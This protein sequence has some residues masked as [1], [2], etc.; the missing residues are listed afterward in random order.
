MQFISHGPE[1][2]E[3]L[4]EAHEEGRVV[5]FCGAGI[6]RKAGLPGFDGLVE[7][8]YDEIG[9]KIEAIEKEAFNRGQFDAALDLLEHRI[10]GQRE[11]VR[12]ALIKVLKPNFRKRG[13]TIVHEAVLELSRDRKGATRLVTTNFDRIFC[14][15][16]KQMKSTVNSYV[17]P[18]LPVPKNS[19]WN[20]VVYLHGL[21]PETED[22]IA[23]DRL[24]L[25]SGDFGLAYLVERWAARFV[26]D[27]FRNYIVC[28]VGYSINDPVLRYMMDALAADRMLGEITPQAY[29][30]GDFH[31]GEESQKKTEWE[32][33]GVIPIL[34][35]VRKHGDHS[36]LHRT[37]QTWAAT[38]RDGVQG[39]ESIVARYALT[40]PTE[41][42][43]QDDFVGRMLWAITHDSGLPARCFANFVPA[44]SLDWLD[45]F[46]EDRFRHSDL[47]R[48]GVTPDN[49][50]KETIKFSVLCR[51]ASYRHTPR[52]GLTCGG[53]PSDWDNLM[54]H[55]AI[56]LLRYL[57]DPA[58]VLWLVKRGGKLHPR[59]AWL[60]EQKLNRILELERAGK[61]QDL[62]R[63]RTDSP[64]SIPT[65]LMRIVWNLL[66]TGRVKMG[67]LQLDIFKWERHFKRDGYTTTARLELRELL[68]PK[69]SLDKPFRWSKEREE[70]SAP[71]K[72]N[73]MFRWQI[74]LA[75]NHVRNCL[76][77]LS[78][79]SQ[80]KAALPRLLADFEHLLMDTL[81]LFQELS[82]G[83]REY[84]SSYIDLPSIIE[85]WQNRGY[86]DWV[87]LVELLR[88]AWTA[89][90]EKDQ[91]K[92]KTYPH[93]WIANSHPTFKRIAFFAASYDGVV[94][95]QKWV[96][97]LLADNCEWLWAKQTKREVMRLL[98]LRGGSLSGIIQTNLE[99]AILSGP[100]RNMFGIDLGDR[101]FQLIA[102][103][104]VWL[105]LAKLASGGL[106]LG[107]KAKK[108]LCC[109]SNENPTLKLDLDELDEFSI[110]TGGTGDPNYHSQIRIHRAPRG[111]GQLAK[112]LSKPAVKDIFYEDDWSEVCRDRFTSSIFAL[113]VLA[114]ENTWPVDRWSHA[115]QAWS[116]EKFVSQSWRRVSQLLRCMPDPVL[117]SLASS[118]TFWLDQLSKQKKLE[119]SDFINLC[120]RI[121]SLP[122]EVSYDLKSPLLMAINHPVGHVVQ[123]IIHQWFLM[124]PADREGLPEEV[125]GIFT[126]LCNS[127][128]PRYRHGLVILAANVI[129][130]F[131]ID[132]DWTV[133][134]LLPF[135]S[136]ERSSVDAAAAWEAYLWSPRLY[137]PLIE[138]LKG[139]FLGCATNYKLLGE[140]GRQY[141]A[142]FTYA[143]LEPGDTFKNE[144]L[145]TAICLFPEEGL[146][147]CANSLF[148]AL[149][150]SGDKREN[151]WKNRLRPFW[152]NIWPKSLALA[153]PS[154]TERLAQLAIAAR[155]EF[156]DALNVIIS[157]LRPVDEVSLLVSDLDKSGL[158]NQFP[159]EALKLLNAVIST[160]HYPPPALASCLDLIVSTKSGIAKDH[161][162]IRLRE[163]SR[164]NR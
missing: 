162:Y 130:I 33:K 60:I 95:P 57:N 35:E 127:A 74:E 43:K 119:W 164:R 12:R 13:A 126:Q 131:R 89:T 159:E 48:F 135:F 72:L 136:W 80:W 44:P 125:E 41:S 101:E 85:H 108:I 129:A 53:Q 79:D 96:G 161:R 137:R 82:T 27:L 156:S 132:R 97:W 150:G 143:A 117:T 163:Y 75:T 134:R 10:V 121:L 99:N 102:S 2:P 9:T 56:W 100:P 47:N 142:I 120:K 86:R 69:V 14:R 7:Q 54:E 6:S 45:L 93:H 67:S 141:A 123:S 98:V 114:R 115:L 103:E 62:D 49:L 146:I 55:F 32:S 157:W 59:F 128:I 11:A 152:K 34:Y 111:R 109:I 138:A 39:R 124:H 94:T 36:L 151:Y 28:F 16:M 63:L 160:D 29:A 68:S 5:F 84:D 70:T 1:V 15:L 90:L 50:Q 122:I 52:M 30:F 71:R 148:N 147:E 24:V 31:V 51:P 77:N 18:L 153:S 144:E 145:S 105:R 106:C 140:S 38:Y 8:I 116:D 87:I 76:K 110:V 65:P 66:L 22:H 88:D 81:D 46:F 113:F 4:L 92:A 91:S 25:T 78:E 118:L 23:L 17:A 58:L 133:A 19:R 104:M 21:L 139:D 3:S 112:W 64:Q 73:E 20:G 37:L 26:S 42:T 155:G 83:E 40:R 158:S 61:K 149:S 107:E 154:L